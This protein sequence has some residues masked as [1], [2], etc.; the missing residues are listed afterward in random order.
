MTGNVSRHRI[1]KGDRRSFESRGEYFDLRAAEISSKDPRFC[2]VLENEAGLPH[3]PLGETPLKGWPWLTL[4]LGSGCL[5]LSSNP[6][7]SPQALERA[8]RDRLDADESDEHAAEDRVLASRYANSMVRSRSIGYDQH[9]GDTP[10]VSLRAAQ[11]LIIAARLSAAFHQLRALNDEAFSRWDDDVALADPVSNDVVHDAPDDLANMLAEREDHYLRINESLN[12]VVEVLDGLRGPTALEWSNG[13]DKATPGLLDEIRNNLVGSGPRQVLLRHCRLVTELAWYYL[14][15]P[16]VYPGWSDLLLKLVVREENLRAFRRP[17]PRSTALVAMAT[18]VRRLYEPAATASN[19][20]VDEKGESVRSRFY[21]AAA[22]ILWR[23][24]TSTKPVGPPHSTAFVTSFDL[25]LPT[26]LYRTAGEGGQFTIAMP[27][28]VLMGSKA[29]E[30]EAVWL[31]A[32]VAPNALVTG[33]NRL[34]QIRDATNWRVGRPESALSHAVPVVVYLGG[35]PLMNIPQG[36]G[37]AGLVREALELTGRNEQ[38]EDLDTVA[39]HH[40]VIIDEYLASRRSAAELFW[41][42]DPSTKQTKEFSRSLP[43]ALMEDNTFN[44]RFWMALGVPVADPAIRTLF[45]TQMTIRKLRRRDAGGPEPEGVVVSRRVDEEEAS[46]LHWFGFDVVRAD[47]A[48]F[49]EDLVHWAAH[50]DERD[51]GRNVTSYGCDLT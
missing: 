4:V 23:Q 44:R 27:V 14:T 45:T 43:R 5:E 6:S 22:R 51:H 11:L 31:L 21:D 33:D 42:S 18:R 40:A 12:R 37:A 47:S 36:S 9:E 35:C 34:R 41:S 50:L 32:D 38:A 39:F 30:A 20:E 7:L 2:V 19:R 28:H 29:T 10:E 13:D 25:E 3:R 15:G 48:D 24:A 17:R 49:V 26:A 1:S 46:V 16:E 8:V